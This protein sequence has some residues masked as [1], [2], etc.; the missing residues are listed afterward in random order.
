MTD[1]KVLLMLTNRFPFGSGEEYLEQEIRHL[2]HAFD[3]VV[4]LPC[5]SAN[6]AAVRDV[7][8]NVQVVRYEQPNH[9][10]GLPRMLARGLNSRA[11]K[12]LNPIA[13]AY[14]GY[15]VGRAMA[16]TDAAVGPLA[17]ALQGD[18]PSVV[19]SYWF[20]VPA[21]VGTLLKQELSCSAPLLSRAHGY[22]VNV[23]ASPVKYLPQRETLLAA[24][25]R[26]HPVSDIATAYLQTTYPQFASK[27]ST[28]RLGTATPPP[29]QPPGSREP[30]HVVT[31]SMIRPLKRLH[32]VGAAVEI[33]RSQGID[34]HWT[35]LGAGSGRYARSLKERFARLPD[36]DFRGYVPNA[37][38][39]QIYAELQP[40]V[41]VNVSTSEG[42][43]VSIMEAMACGLP[44]LATDVGGTKEILGQNGVSSMLAADIT[45]TELAQS[46]RERIWSLPTPDY[47]SL[48]AE[49]KHRWLEVSCADRI[50]T[51][52]ARELTD[53]CSTH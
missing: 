16:I 48:C 36:V 50:Y 26:V 14:D 28:R 42:V 3:R 29:D 13:L 52:F 33:L 19:Y 39:Y 7:P 12:R 1:S 49:S 38:I 23:H 17:E 47:S 22:D 40:S 18:A 32:L 24:C 45:A 37:E 9:R 44:V 46:I 15:F 10:R 6:T 30:L 5:M 35:H 27:V 31:C 2:A 20:Y 41:F 8:S 4:I 43:P 25:D 34:A 21:M 53:Q 51:Q 11:G